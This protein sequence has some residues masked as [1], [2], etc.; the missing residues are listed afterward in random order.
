MERIASAGPGSL[1]LVCGT[2]QVQISR[3]R[4]AIRS[5]FCGLLEYEYATM[6]GEDAE[7]GRL[8]RLLDE[9]S[10]FSPG[11]IVRLSDA[12][13]FPAAVRRE[14][15]AAASV[16]GR[17]DS[18]L[19]ESTDTS[20]RSAFNAGID[21]IPG[22][23]SFICWDPFERDFSRWCDTLAGE[24]GLPLTSGC[25]SMLISWAGGSLS[26]L[27]DAV[28]RAALF[29][30][31]RTMAPAELA[32]LLTGLADPEVFDLADE[33]WAGRRGRALSLA[34]RLIQAG[35]EPVALLAL[36]QRQWER[37]ETARAVLAA[38]GGQ[39]D[40]ERELGLTSTS[41]ASLVSSARASSTPPIWK[42]SELLASS[43]LSLKTGADP[44]TVFAGLIHSLTQG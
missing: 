4:E 38:G 31:G 41:A 43:D 9:P 5:R 21:K 32:G 8:T 7:P 37:L 13:R 29:S 33:I 23:L 26:R 20:L 17:T 15:T 19:V 1:F 35:E 12:D 2:E 24:R 16:P 34:W 6:S 40:V 22:S 25:R 18:I 39:K 14:L 10:L 11:R 42:A 27:D 30:G 36:I 28:S 3:I 44:F